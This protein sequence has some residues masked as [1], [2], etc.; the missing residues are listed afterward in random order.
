ML[1]VDGNKDLQDYAKREFTKQVL[2]VSERVYHVFGY[3]HSNAVIII[4]ENSVILVDALNSRDSGAALKALIAEITP[5][6]VKTIIYTHSHPDH[7]G[8]SGAFRD[9]VEEIIAFGAKNKPL[10]YSEKIMQGLGKRTMR[11]FGYALND[12]EMI[13]QGIGI[14]EDKS[15]YDILPATRIYHDED[16]VEIEIDGV[17]LKLV[18]ACGETDD[19]LFVWLAEEKALC[20]GDNYYACWPNLYAIRGISY[21]DVAAW[22]DSLDMMLGYEAEYLLPGHTRALVGAQKVRE[23]LSNYRDAIKY[24]LFQTLE[25]INQGIGVDEAV[26]MVKLPQEYASLEYLGEHYGSVDWSVRSIYQGYA[27]WFDGKAVNLHRLSEK[28]R[29]VEMTAA[30]GGIDKVFGLIQEAQANKKWQWS[31]E[32]CEA[33]LSLEDNRSVLECKVRALRA[34]AELE[35]SAN[36]RHYYLVS[37]YEAEEKL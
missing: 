36:G 25:C 1:K 13:T 9:T 23:V 29:A 12:E 19:Q 33:V 2:K 21:R 37:A 34:L 14:R 3:G 32:L 4:G 26:E 16:V 15:G 22:V 18:R 30:L 28:E 20:S 11:Q 8:G 5:K 7:L 24:V 27:G 6:P 31:L 35:T 17:N 10:K